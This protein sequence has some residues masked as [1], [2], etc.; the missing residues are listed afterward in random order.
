VNVQTVVVPNY[1]GDGYSR[2][3]SPPPGLVSN[4]NYAGNEYLRSISPPPGYQVHQDVAVMCASS[5]EV[6]IF[7]LL[8][9]GL[10]RARH[11]SVPSH[12]HSGGGSVNPAVSVRLTKRFVS[13]LVHMICRLLWCQTTQAVCLRD[14]HS[15]LPSFLT[16][17]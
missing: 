14:P 2:S 4:L 10:H 17:F 7:L 1:A 12:S 5:P 11:H 16:E 3:S 15:A 13:P 6:L 8:R 9:D